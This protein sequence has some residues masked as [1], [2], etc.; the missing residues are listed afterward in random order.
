M[1]R[2]PM[3]PELADNLEGSQEGRKRL[4]VIL[5]TVAGRK[6]VEEAARELGVSESRFHEMRAQALGAALSGL[7]PSPAG[8]PKK[9]E[10]PKDR[11]LR[12]KDEEL[13]EL[14]IQLRSAQLREEI[15]AVMPNLVKP[16][17]GGKKSGGP[18][19]GGRAAKAGREAHGASAR[20]VGA[21]E[22]AGRKEG[23]GPGS[24]GAGGAKGAGAAGAHVGGGVREVA[25]QGRDGSRGSRQTP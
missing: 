7:E 15:A 5:E 2:K 24:G 21:E 16:R 20:G 12:E 23:G 18:A 19:Q 22:R 9:E 6:G 10:D 11:L 1:A 25:R 14:K 17:D 13:L 3:G 4:R 8:R